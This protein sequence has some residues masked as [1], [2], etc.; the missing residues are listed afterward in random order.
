MSVVP[1]LLQMIL[2]TQMMN[3]VGDACRHNIVRCAA[4]SS[5]VPSTA[6]PGSTTWT[7]MWVS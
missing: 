1:M 4:R 2:V 6:G 7:T 5:V 3:V